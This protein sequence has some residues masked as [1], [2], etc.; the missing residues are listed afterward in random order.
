MPMFHRLRTDR[1]SFGDAFYRRAASGAY[2]DCRYP[3]VIL[4]YLE[5]PRHSSARGTVGLGN[6]R[7][8]CDVW[9][10]PFIATRRRL[11]KNRAIMA[12]ATRVSCRNESGG[13]CLASAGTEVRRHYPSRT[14]RLSRSKIDREGRCGHRELCM[15]WPPSE[16]GPRGEANSLNARRSVIQWF[17]SGGF[18]WG[19]LPWWEDHLLLLPR[20]VARPSALAESSD[21]LVGVAR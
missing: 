4:A 13:S 12:V 2:A 11:R 9:R 19:W 3:A 7:A 18:W 21:S 1:G 20:S 15:L 14:N 10:P 8:G 6:R 17:L 5:I 16:Y